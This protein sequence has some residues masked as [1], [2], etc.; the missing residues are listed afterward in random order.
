MGFTLKQL[1]KYNSDFKL[2]VVLKY[3]SGRFTIFQ[4]CNKF[5][6]D[7]TTFFRTVFRQRNIKTMPNKT[8]NNYPLEFKV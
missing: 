4:I 7:V 5:G 3:L 8:R 6:I 1:K 2:K